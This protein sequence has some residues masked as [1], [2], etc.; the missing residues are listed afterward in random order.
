MS[1]QQRPLPRGG[2]CTGPASRTP[3]PRGHDDLRTPC[4]KTAQSQT[5]R[6]QSPQTNLRFLKSG[7]VRQNSGQLLTSVL[8]A[9]KR[10]DLVPTAVETRPGHS[11]AQQATVH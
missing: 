10:C 9:K 11:E 6:T 2:S 3:S 8:Q 7:S 4:R 5:S 1:R